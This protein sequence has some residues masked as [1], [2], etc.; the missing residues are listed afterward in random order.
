ML[1]KLSHDVE[2]DKVI[3]YLA[4]DCHSIAGKELAHALC[5]INDKVLIN[6]R[7]TLISEIQ[8]AIKHGIEIDFTELLP[9]DEL[10]KDTNQV[11]YDYE[12]FRL[13][14]LNARLATEIC[15][16][17]DDF[18]GYKELYK[19]LKKLFPLPQ[20]CKN[21]EQIFDMDEEVKDSASEELKR[22]RRKK[23][24]LREHIIRSL[25][26]K[27]TDS[28]FE[29]ALQEKF[30]TQRD[31]R[32]VIPVK[33]THVSQIKGIVQGHSGSK[34]TVFMEPEDVV[35]VNN[36]LQML[37]QEEKREIFRIFQAFTDE[38]RA[39]QNQLNE[40]YKNLANLDCWFSCGRLSKFLQARIPKI[41]D[42]TTLCFVKARH[43]LLIMQKGE[44]SKVIPFELELGKDYDFLILS[45]PN[46]GGKTVLLKAVGLLTLMALTGLPIPAEENT[47]IGMFES[48]VADIGDEQSIEQALSTFSSHISKIKAMLDICNE[49]SLVLLDEIGAATDPQQG[50]A[51]AQAIMEAFNAKNVKGMVTTHYTALKVFAEKSERC[52]NAAMQFDMK[53]LVPTYRFQLGFPGD[54]FAI[55]VAASLGL[56]QDLI[57]RAKVLTGSQNL[58]FTELI[59][60][61]QEE[62]KTLAT[63]SWQ[64]KLKN[65]NLEASI[66]EYELRIKR[67]DDEQKAKRKELLKEFQQELINNQKKLLQEMESLKNTEKD[68]RKKKT[69]ELV[70]KL[71]ELQ[72]DNQSKIEGI[73]SAKRNKVFDPKPGDNIWLGNFE[74]DAIIVDIK[75]DDVYVDMNGITF[76][77]KRE[78]IF[79]SQKK[80]ESQPLPLTRVKSSPQAHFELKLLG[81]TFDE[82]QP[83]IDDFIDSAFS[84][85]L[86][87]LRIVHGKGTGA[88][89][90]KVR[91]YLK[92]IKLVKTIGT[93]PQETGGSGVTVITI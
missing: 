41:I 87:S 66:S 80:K 72:S 63:E 65:R 90:T 58:E 86:H 19:N 29:N 30:V 20:I 14:Y 67:F 48:V 88:L 81:F 35:G 7:L 55:E 40:N 49:K 31:G 12:E 42:E 32:Y 92:M 27:F 61:L 22:I 74:T 13:A 51:L 71:Q 91:N 23:V 64:S 25:Q 5:P 44:V 77:T 73:E 45:G 10:F 33:E 18:D 46:T 75:D 84:A 53:S 52:T 17:R 16:R 28:S 85:G 83:L 36:D 70:S 60:K 3:D 79:E 38:V 76:K 68:E 9:L 6:Y 89:R 21:F 8:D 78:N 62:K 43:P 4:N 54:S 50:S 24:L 69:T 26:K 93:P 47:E 34:A 56:H 59:K 37:Q 15:T 2:Y 82:A 1:H 11:V 57:Q 39:L